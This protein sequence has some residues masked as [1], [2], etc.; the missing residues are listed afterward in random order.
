MAILN[1]AGSVLVTGLAAAA[2]IGL[3][4]AATLPK[5][6][7]W[8]VTPGGAIKA[9]SG[10]ITLSDTTTGNSISCTSSN[11]TGTLKSGKGLAGKKIGTITAFTTS[12]CTAS[13]FSVTV[14]PSGFPWK[15]NLTK[16]KSGV[17]SGSISGIKASMSVSGLSCT[18]NVGGA[19]AT[20]AGTA[21]IT[22]TNT[23]SSLAVSGAKPN[24]IHLWNVSSGCLG[25]VNTGDAASIT[26]T[27][28]VT[29]AQ[30]I[31]SP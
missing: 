28:P 9:T 15:L 8:T 16:F 30:T 29:P 26:S 21:A 2:V 12:G 23:G 5:A 7:T 6:V 27:A 3:S 25:V 19:T 20:S 10:T 13:G 4:T 31:T 24:N 11:L 17:S 14:T 22:F 18:G 1:R